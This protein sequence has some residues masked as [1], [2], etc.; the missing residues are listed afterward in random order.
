[1]RKGRGMKVVKEMVRM[2]STPF[3]KIS[4]SSFYRI[5]FLYNVCGGRGGSIRSCINEGY[6]SSHN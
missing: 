3:V 2:V 1:M 6:I 4:S 5:V